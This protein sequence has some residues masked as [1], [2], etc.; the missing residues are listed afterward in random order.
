MV[1]EQ[2]DA[3]NETFIKRANIASSQ[4]F[5]LAV[6]ANKSITK[7]WSG[8]IYTNVYNNH[9]KGDVNNEHISIG[10]TSFMVQLQ[11][12][13]KLGKGWAAEVSGFYAS[14]SIWHASLKAA[15][16]WS[17]DGGIQKQL[18]NGKATIKASVSDI[19]KTMKWTAESKFDVQRLTAA[20]R[21]DSRQFKLN[22]SY[23]FG[24]QKL[25][26]ARQYKTG[27]E[28]ETNR[29]QSSGGLGH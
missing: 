21:S 22:F 19:F 12:Q 26:A 17:V 28:G 10:I 11:Q 25:K 18:W 2:N 8:N 9:F 13:F 16:I 4:Q 27:L 29:T 5:G 23:R 20:G 15:S 24:N 6:T 1:L 3:T 7:W 14:P